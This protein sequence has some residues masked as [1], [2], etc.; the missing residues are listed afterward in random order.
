MSEIIIASSATNYV[1]QHCWLAI[2]DF[3][4]HGLKKSQTLRLRPL[5]SL[6]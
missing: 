6:P 4:L 2:A 5:K 3:K 1:T